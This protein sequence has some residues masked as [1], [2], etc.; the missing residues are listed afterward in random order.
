MYQVHNFGIDAPNETHTQRERDCTN[1]NSRQNNNRM[2]HKTIQN[3]HIA[4]YTNVNE[5]KKV[6]DFYRISFWLLFTLEIPLELFEFIIIVTMNSLN[7]LWFFSNIFSA[8]I[9]DLKLRVRKGRYDGNMDVRLVTK[10]QQNCSQ[11][12]D[13]TV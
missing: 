13:Q 10:S 7:N 9:L 1:C 12:L 8:L 5:V 11:K 3:S 4:I 2:I 6:F